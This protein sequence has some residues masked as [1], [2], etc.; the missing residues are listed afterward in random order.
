MSR[1]QVSLEFLLILGFAIF[2][3]VAMLSIAA[4]ELSNA[5]T[6][7]TLSSMQDIGDTIQ[8]ELLTARSVGDGYNRTFELPQRIQSRQYTLQVQTDNFTS[9]VISITTAKRTISVR[10]PYCNGT[11]VPGYNRIGTMN[12][13]IR[14]NQ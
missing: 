5:T 2:L 6:E 3:L 8:L 12:G 4:Y 14:C 13:T 7:T 1:A 11:L 10:T 9:S